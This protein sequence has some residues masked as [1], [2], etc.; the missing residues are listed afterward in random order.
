MTPPAKVYFDRNENRYGPAPACMQVLRE[1]EGELLF[2]YSRTFQR[3]YYS[4]LSAR[5]AAIHGV[6]EQRIILGF[7]GGFPSWLDF[8]FT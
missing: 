6:D 4:E 8:K 5:L 3:G 1:A 7:H 2:N